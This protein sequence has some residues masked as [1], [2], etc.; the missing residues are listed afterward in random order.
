MGKYNMSGK[1]RMA[2]YAVNLVNNERGNSIRTLLLTL[3]LVIAGASYVYFFT[4][5]IRPDNGSSKSLQSSAAPEK[6]PL[7]PRTDQQKEGSTSAKPLADKAQSNPLPP[8][9]AAVTP[10]KPA[11]A[12]KSAEHSS[13]PAKKEQTKDAVPVQTVKTA[14][15]PVGVKAVPQ[16]A[17]PTQAKAAQSKA[18]SNLPKSAKEIIS[19]EL[20]TA[21][22]K[23][24]KK[25]EKKI[26]GAYSLLIG[27]FVPDKTMTTALVRLKKNGISPVK[28]EVVFANEPMNRLL[29][30]EYT[31]QD[32]SVAE[33]QKLKKLTGDAF[34]IAE[35]DKY[36]LYAG[37]YFTDSRLKQESTRLAAKGVKTVVRTVHVK[38][39]VT[40]I[41]AGSFTSAESAHIA[42]HELGK[43]GLKVKVVKS[44]A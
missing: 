33:L 26:T 18:N 28:K 22:G 35:A 40:R 16:P 3:V 15:P 5:L 29:V 8:P 32:V 10:T 38:I 39:K 43:T 6:K 1:G 23:S 44:G 13:L 19:P 42:A 7:P 24:D 4:D 11:P 37:S 41:R 2:N 34:L 9:V 27:D 30:G 14:P 25:V 17:K 20:K 12:V 31:D 21:S 36:S